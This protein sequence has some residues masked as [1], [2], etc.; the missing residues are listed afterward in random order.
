MPPRPRYTTPGEEAFHAGRGPSRLTGTLASL[1]KD[2][3]TFLHTQQEAQDAQLAA[4][5]GVE[6]LNI[7]FHRLSEY[8]VEELG[9][10]QK[11]QRAQGEEAARQRAHTAQELKTLRREVE[12]LQ[13]GS[14]GVSGKQGDAVDRATL[15]HVELQLNQELQELRDVCSAVRRFAEQQAITVRALALQAQAKAEEASRGVDAH[16][17]K[18]DAMEMSILEARQELAELREQCAALTL[19]QAELRRAAQQAEALARGQGA[20]S[21]RAWEP[22]WL[23][24]EPAWDG[25]GGGGES[26]PRTPHTTD[27]RQ[28]PV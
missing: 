20:A 28:D 12:A 10:L 7:A 27:R 4:H 15:R 5:E 26:P 11:A 16:G 17:H 1:A 22:S 2:A 6:K 25:G 19:E 21:L 18:R 3:E 23:G 13:M 9:A 24:A 14:A 8:V